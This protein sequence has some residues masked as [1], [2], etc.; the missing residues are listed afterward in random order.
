MQSKSQ[1]QQEAEKRTHRTNIPTATY[2]IQFNKE[3]RFTHGTAIVPYLSELGISHVYASPFFRARPGS[4]HG[5]DIIDHQVLNAEIG[6]REEFEE[7][8]ATL[9][10]HGMGLIVDF[11]PNHMGIGS[12]NPWWMDVL[13]NGAASQY[14]N[15]FDIDW[16][17]VKRELYG[18]VLI[19]V[20]G[21][22]YGKIL[23]SGQLKLAFNS[24]K[25]TIIVHYYDH[26][27][28]LDPVSYPVVLG[29][30]IG[31][32]EARLSSD[33]IDVLEFKSILSALEMLPNHIEPVG[34]AQRIG[35]KIVQTRRLAE[36]CSHSGAIRD[37]ID[38]NINAFNVREG[39][40]VSMQR[41]HDLLE[42]QP[43][44]LAYWRVA[45]DEI[46][47]RRFFDIN[48]LAAIRTEDPQVFNAIHSLVFQ[49]VADGLVDG[50][51]ID[52]PDGLFDPETYFRRLQQVSAEKL[53]LEF[54]PPS[55][56]G[57]E[58]HQSLP[59]YIVAEK[60]LAPFEQL[61]ENWLVHGTTGY[62]FMDALNNLLVA[63]ENEAQFTNIYEEFVGQKMN[64]EAMRRVAKEVILDTVLSSEL[65]VLAHRLS[66]IAETSWFFRDFTLSSLRAALRNFV[67]HFPVY[68]TYTSG[69]GVPDSAKQYIDWA[70]TLAKR[71]SRVPWPVY[72]FVAGVLKG[73]LDPEMFGVTDAED[74]F[75][76]RQRI[77][78]FAM[79]FQQFTGPVTAKSV[80]DTLFYRYNRLVCLNEVGAEPKRFGTSAAAFHRQ[81][82][83]RQ[84]KR[85]YS[86]LGTSTHDT[87]RSED[88]RA[89]IAVLSEIPDIWRERVNRWAAMNEVHK[90]S[91]DEDLIPDRNDE[92]LL[93]QNIIGAFPHDDRSDA[94]MAVFRDR[95]KQYAM[96]AIKEAKVHTSWVVPNEDYENGIRQFVEK[97]LTP[98]TNN[99]FL[100]DMQEFVDEISPFGFANATSQALLKLTSPGVPDI[101]QGNELWDFSLVD[102]DNRRPIDFAARADLLN[103]VEPGL[104]A[105]IDGRAPQHRN[106][107]DVCR[108]EDGTMKLYLTTAILRY[109]KL[110]PELFT[111]GIYMQL[112]TT[113]EHAAHVL[114]FA[115]QYEGDTA[116]LVVPLKLA[117]LCKCESVDQLF[118]P[119]IWK[120]TAVVLP[121]EIGTVRFKN[122]FTGA[123]VGQNDGSLRIADLFEQFPFVLLVNS[124]A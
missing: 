83:I 20:L 1:T 117:A 57:G 66:R 72:D 96:K 90:A 109:R 110:K 45:S 70:V 106:P 79:R 50:I 73:D 64:Y 121:D 115:R 95:I 19:P 28:P 41:M 55:T 49:M 116:I 111:A 88:V 51:R 62:E 56:T 11:V 98:G 31:E 84:E 32:L 4:M 54:K 74:V 53:G 69:N 60:I 29:E 61:E 24:E 67:V 3:F 5:Y 124:G 22:S 17:P 113:G 103:R 104:I 63:E 108:W 10:R 118:A 52:H 123:A 91:K 77:L 36:L 76:I 38:E 18:K 82:Q 112:E 14:A 58:L 27:L 40:A 100:V 71:N 65:N 102:P 2:R 34:F 89:R 12:D 75:A 80:E 9:R 85:P 25:G 8:V 92:Y 122:L 44:R 35:E 81:N 30:R 6:T 120:N 23:E 43:Y 99:K 39:D 37:F 13:E 78:D 48:D 86:M 21:E 68:R 33:N 59:I 107:L 94:A 46:N 7:F 26:S 101:Y 15:Y 105:E 42:S 16:Q 119:Q 97:I 87:K 47:Y 93:Y 114:A